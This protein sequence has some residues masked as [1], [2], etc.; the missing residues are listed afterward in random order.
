MLL[1]IGQRLDHGFDE[2]LGLLRD[3][4]R[5]I[6]H[7]LHVLQAITREVAGGPLTE[8]QR[9]QLE[10]ALVY[11]ATVTPRHSADE[12]QSLFPGGGPHFPAMALSRAARP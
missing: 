3:C 5:R 9:A 12:E 1:K 11:F 4:H 2:P 7:F 10:S 8:E 6:E